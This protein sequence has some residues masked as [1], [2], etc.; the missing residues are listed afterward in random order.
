MPVP[1]LISNENT[2]IIQSPQDFM[3]KY[4]LKKRSYAGVVFVEERLLEQELKDKGLV[5]QAT[6]Q[7]M[8]S[9]IVSNHTF[10]EMLKVPGSGKYNSVMISNLA[11]TFENFDTVEREKFLSDW[12]N[13]FIKK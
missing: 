11:T 3:I 6:R 1:A 8:M 12:K 10:S 13:V 7:N 4:A 9:L 5:D 2:D